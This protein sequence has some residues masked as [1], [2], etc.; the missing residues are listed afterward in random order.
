MDPEPIGPQNILLRG[1]VLRNT[2]WIIGCV[3]NTGHH[4][5]IL[6]S[7]SATPNK[8]M[9][10]CILFPFFLVSCLNAALDIRYRV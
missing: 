2:D 1:C 7:A 5:K 8:V 6:M 4:T 9:V 10:Y 3:V